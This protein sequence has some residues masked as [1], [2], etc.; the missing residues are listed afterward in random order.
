MFAAC[1]LCGRVICYVAT[2][3]LND[4]GFSISHNKLEG[5]YSGVVDSGLFDVTQDPHSPHLLTLP[6]RVHWPL[7]SCLAF[8]DPN[9]A[10]TTPDTA[11]LIS[12]MEW[13]RKTPQPQVP[14][15]TCRASYRS[16]HITC[17]CPLLSGITSTWSNACGG[18]VES[19]QADRPS[20]D[21]AAG[22]VRE[23]F[24][25]SLHVLSPHI[26]FVEGA[27]FMPRCPVSPPV[28]GHGR[29]Q[30]CAVSIQRGPG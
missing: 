29:G 21:L 7:S 13:K 27:M 6:S 18:S 9:V 8:C 28:P 26:H 22:R 10:A 1:L 17:S 15:W 24:S 20:R 2:D 25:E 11:S 4:K 23:W 14:Q 3:C 5:G 16:R 19:C 30:S 12:C